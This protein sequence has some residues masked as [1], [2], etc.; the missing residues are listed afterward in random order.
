MCKYNSHPRKVNGPTRLGDKSTFNY[1]L[2]THRSKI[3]WPGFLAK[4]TCV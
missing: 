3:M 1:P 2:Y 4:P